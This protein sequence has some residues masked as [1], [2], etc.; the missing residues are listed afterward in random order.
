VRDE[1]L[2]PGIARYYKIQNACWSAKV[3]VHP[4]TLGKVPLVWDYDILTEDA[5]SSKRI[6]LCRIQCKN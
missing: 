5:L 1:N 2:R 6:R 3:Q 4:K